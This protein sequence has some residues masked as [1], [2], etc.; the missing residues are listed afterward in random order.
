MATLETLNVIVTAKTGGVVKGFK[1]A[2]AAAQRF[3]NSVTGSIAKLAGIGAAVV[4]IHSVTRAITGAS[5]RSRS[6]L[7]VIRARRLCSK[8]FRI[9]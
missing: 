2:G 3:G 9:Y 1:G 7:L 6:T 4:G 8:R 5:I